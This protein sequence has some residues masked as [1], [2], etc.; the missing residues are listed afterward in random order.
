MLLNEISCESRAQN[1]QLARNGIAATPG[2]T[3]CQENLLLLFLLAAIQSEEL[4]ACL[5]TLVNNLIPSTGF[6][7]KLLEYFIHLHP[8]NLHGYDIAITLV[9]RFQMLKQTRQLFLVRFIVLLA[10]ILVIDTD[11]LSQIGKDNL[12]III[13]AFS[14]FLV[15]SSVSAF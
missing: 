10:R 11:F 13:L 4:S 5:L 1:D 15:I 3:L 8:C 14:I 12:W 6:Q 7:L 9:Y 2:F